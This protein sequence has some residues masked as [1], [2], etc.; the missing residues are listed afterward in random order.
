M[1]TKSAFKL[2]AGQHNYSSW[3]MRPWILL[4]ECGFDFE[5]VPVDVEG[6]GFNTK[7][8]AYSPSGL[9]PCILTPDG[10]QVWD[11]MGIAEW[12]AER[13]PPGTVWPVDPVARAFARCVALEMHSG[14][15]DVRAGMPCNFKMR[16][17][18]AQLSDKAKEQLERIATIWTEART[19]IGK[20]SGAG[21]Y[22]F[23]VFSAADAMYAPVVSRFITYNIDLKRW[24]IAL[25]YAATMYNN[26]HYQTW[27]AS[28][29]LETNAIGHYDEAALKLGNGA[30][31]QSELSDIEEEAA[32]LKAASSV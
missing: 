21:P 19:R 15:V 1:A 17:N 2:F 31:P 20:P 22:L 11:S 13:T 8:L 5:E 24:P 7:H 26:A 23:G 25:E 32:R 6:K 18:G 10:Q 9:V 27:A 16:T 12:L 30:R 14:F 4:K 28:A 3:S 29:L